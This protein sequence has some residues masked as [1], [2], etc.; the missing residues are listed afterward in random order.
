MLYFYGRNWLPQDNDKAKAILQK[1]YDSGHSESKGYYEG[2]LQREECLR[3]DAEA[4]QAVIQSAD[5]GDVEARFQAAKYYENGAAGLTKDNAKALEYLR[6]AADE[7]ALASAQIYLGNAYDYAN[8][9]LEED[10][11][12][13][14]AWYRRAADL[15]SEDGQFKIGEFYENG[16][17]GLEK[18]VDTAK[19][20]FA[21]AGYNGQAAIDRIEE[22][23]RN[24][25]EVARLTEA[26]AKGDPEAQA[27]LGWL[28]QYGQK[29][30]ALDTTRAE[31]LYRLSADQANA[32]GNY[33]LGLYYI[34]EVAAKYFA[35]AA[36]QGNYNASNARSIAQCYF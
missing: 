28:H 20:Y 22:P 36:D 18:N 8:L 33:Y 5:G 32:L 16:F 29:G 6:L 15:G 10:D 26:V 34:K 3:H 12:T 13:A 11:V 7:G 27:Q 31:E 25:A 21:K 1:G 14:L 19:E 24:R 4:V 30:V 9:G 2:I 23:E 17:G 35:L